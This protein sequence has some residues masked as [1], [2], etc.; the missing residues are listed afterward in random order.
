MSS[1]ECSSFLLFTDPNNEILGISE[2]N[3]EEIIITKEKK[4]ILI[5]NV[6]FFNKKL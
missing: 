6:F 4:G 1:L 5:Y 3:Q 2:F